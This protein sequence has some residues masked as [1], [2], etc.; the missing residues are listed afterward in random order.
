MIEREKPKDPSALGNLGEYLGI[1][2]S[3]WLAAERR[4]KL[5]KEL[6]RNLQRRLLHQT[7]I[8][9]ERE[10]MSN[11]LSKIFDTKQSA[12]NAVSILSGGLQINCA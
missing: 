1:S 7:F 9:L 12:S 3:E 6:N 2:S 4:E 5:E 8:T 10:I 11:R